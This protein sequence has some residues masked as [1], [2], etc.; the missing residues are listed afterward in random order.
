MNSSWIYGIVLIV[1]HVLN[2]AVVASNVTTRN[3]SGNV[4]NGQIYLK[5]HD[6]I[7]L[8]TS[9]NM[10]INQYFNNVWKL[11][12]WKCVQYAKVYNIT[13]ISAV[14]ISNNESMHSE[15]ER[16]RLLQTTSMINAMQLKK[17]SYTKAT[18]TNM[19]KS[20]LSISLVSYGS[21]FKLL[22]YRKKYSEKKGCLRISRDSKCEGGVIVYII[23]FI[24][25]DLK[26]KNKNSNKLEN[27]EADV[28]ESTIQSNEH[29]KLCKRS[30]A[31]IGPAT[32]FCSQML[33]VPS[34]RKCRNQPPILWHRYVG[35]AQLLRRCKYNQYPIAHPR[36]VQVQTLG[37]DMQISKAILQLLSK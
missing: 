31:S 1:L 11:K 14:Q 10:L 27:C 32:F 26:K 18:A 12:K 33:R 15:N 3:S 9:W 36:K 28:M 22:M 6:M 35:M 30:R 13:I 16:I 37:D 8:M 29:F 5:N 21:S 34:Q 23:D 19:F 2:V 24:K 20:N 4:T 25:I 17:N 7:I